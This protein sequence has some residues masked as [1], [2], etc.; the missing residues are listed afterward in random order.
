[1]LAT[2]HWDLINPS[3]SS[4]C[5]VIVMGAG[6]IGGY[7]ALALAKMGFPNIYV[8]DFDVVAEENISPQIY[9]PSYIGKPKTEALRQVIL[10]LSG[11]N[12]K[13]SCNKCVEIPDQ[14]TLANFL[15][16]IPNLIVISAIDSMEARKNLFSICSASKTVKYFIDSRMAIQFLNCYA[17]DLYDKES[18]DKYRRTLFKDTEAIQE[19]CTNKSIAFTSMI[20]GGIVAKLTMDCVK[21]IDSEVTEKPYSNFML[22]IEHYDSVYFN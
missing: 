6:S 5:T 4:K 14:I 8:D 10:D 15:A 2:R 21:K 9:G 22:H 17:I 18:I 13:Q 12:I 11:V 7:S 20:A 19:P 16:R 3:Q 1:M